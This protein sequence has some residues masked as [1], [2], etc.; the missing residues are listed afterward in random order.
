MEDSQGQTTMYETKDMAEKKNGKTMEEDTT[1]KTMEDA[2]A[3][4][5]DREHNEGVRD[6]RGRH[7]R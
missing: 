3:A 6:A 4:N 1:E 5:L 2:I 7:C